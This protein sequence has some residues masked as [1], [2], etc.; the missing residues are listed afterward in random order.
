[1]KRIYTIVIFL[2]MV[3]T[4]SGAASEKGQI[5][6]VG[7]RHLGMAGTGVALADDEN[8]ILYNPTGL[9]KMVGWEA[10]IPFMPFSMTPNANIV[11]NGD[12]FKMVDGTLD[13]EDTDNIIRRAQLIEEVAA[14]HPYASIEGGL[15]PTFLKRNLG[16]GLL[17]SAVF[18]TNTRPMVSGGP[19]VYESLDLVTRGFI[20]AGGLASYGRELP[21]KPVLFGTE[22]DLYAGGTLKAIWRGYMRRIDRTGKIE[23]DEEND[24]PQEDEE[25][26]D[27]L[28]WDGG[29]GVDLAVRL[30]LNDARLTAASLVLYNL[31]GGFD[32][33]YDD[34]TELPV[35]TSAALGF[36]SKPFTHV[37]GIESLLVGFDIKEIGQGGSFHLGMEYPSGIWRFRMGLSGDGFATG[38]GV[39]WRV[40]KFDY[41]M[42]KTD[43]AWFGDDYRTRNH[44]LRM[45]LD[46]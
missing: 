35:R 11:L 14:D 46:L 27:D 6:F 44:V 30:E 32:F 24:E 23:S 10:T 17:V 4:E 12:L 9:W 18:G 42:H 40:I 21:W 34:G 25:E 29:L 16:I 39:K 41:A 45:S 38:A 33:S 26:D 37:R 15:F 19:D 36:A 20:D 3:L 1:M 13:I 31:P 28:S 7:A 8:A 5:G 22:V 43:N 2:C